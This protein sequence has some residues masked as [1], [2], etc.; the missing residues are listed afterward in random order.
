MLREKD[1]PWTV[2]VTGND[3]PGASEPA[4]AVLFGALLHVINHGLFKSL[5]FY[6]AGAVVHAT[7]SRE[8]DQFHRVKAAF[9][10]AAL[11]NPGNLIP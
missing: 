3:P 1:I 6:S 11:L 5:L 10:P 9:D 7:G 8:L 2:A 4:S